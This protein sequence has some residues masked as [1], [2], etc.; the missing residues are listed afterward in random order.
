MTVFERILKK[1]IPAKIVYEDEDVLAFHDVAPQAPIHVLV[2]P[3]QKYVDYGS[4]AKADTALCG[5]YFQKIAAV[6]KLLGL[7]EG[8][9]RVVFNQGRDAQ[10]SVMYLHAHILGGRMLQWPPG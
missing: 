3:K 2:I 7:E 4:M 5:R 8:G 1:E 6:A 9:Y 10:Q